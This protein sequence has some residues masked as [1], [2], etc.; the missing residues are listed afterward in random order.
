[1]KKL[2]NITKNQISQKGVQALSDRPNSSRKYGEGGLS[3]A[4]LKAWFDKLSA[5]LAE[6]INEIQDVMAADD[7]AEY[8]RVVL[9]E[10][11]V[12]DLNE[13][14]QAF[15]SAKAASDFFK[16]Y[17]NIAAEK[18]ELLQNVINDLEKKISGFSEKLKDLGYGYTAAAATAVEDEGEPRIDV[19]T[20]NYDGGKKLVFTFCNLS[21]MIPRPFY[22]YSAYPDGTDFSETWSAEHKY[23]GI[24]VGLEAPT[25]KS[26]YSWT[27]YLSPTS[28]NELTDV[29]YSYLDVD[30]NGYLCLSEDKTIGSPMGFVGQIAS[31]ALKG[32]VI[33]SAVAMKDV[34]PLEHELD[35]KV[36]RKNLIP[37]PYA[38][39][40]K[41]ENGITFTDNGDG[42]I[43]ANGTATNNAVFYMSFETPIK[44][45]KYT[46]SGCPQGGGWDNYLIALN[47]TRGDETVGGVRDLGDGAFQEFTEPTT[48]QTYI[49]ILG[50]A[51]VNNLIFKPQ[52]EKGTATPYAPYLDDVSS[53]EV[54]RYGKNLLPYPYKDTTV[55]KNGITFTDNGD[56]TVTANG[57]ATDAA[58]FFVDY[59]LYEYKAGT[60]TISGADGGSLG[61]NSYHIQV[62]SL[63]NTFSAFN[64]TDKHN[65][66]MDRAD[67]L[68]IQLVV[69]KGYTVNNL[70]FK[71]QLE[72]GTTATPYEPYVEPTT[73]AVE[74][75]GAVNGVMSLYP[76]T[77]LITDNRALIE[78]EYNRDINKAFEELTQI[79]ISLGGNI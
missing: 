56:G 25:D 60:Y 14:I 66:T 69:Y 24:Y 78:C 18:P 16:V 65:F 70:I 22:R 23:I 13:F 61:D 49:L 29:P 76:S 40:T 9:D 6:K 46:L 39:T 74:A 27:L 21:D 79:I 8:I 17:P 71:P 75:D 58:I 68:I 2:T 72:V 42:T 44:A 1:M 31:N 7:G 32:S 19:T 28:F 67:K 45:G 10:V 41:T 59:F 38:E 3:A 33:G 57:T 37:Y 62:A 54:K 12:T 11:G 50:G 34:S 52:F 47:Y 30:E 73:Y 26:G 53:V 55:T 15:V 35:V 64:V 77:T 36:S 20:E 5:F 63:N 43:T 51:T 48:V 4:Q